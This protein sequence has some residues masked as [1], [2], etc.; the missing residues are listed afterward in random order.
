MNVDDD[1]EVRFILDQLDM[2]LHCDFFSFDLRLFTRLDNTKYDDD[3]FK[4]LTA[5]VLLVKYMNTVKPAL[6]STT[7]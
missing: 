4:I 5:V 6:K 7:I 3:Q 2:S 1:D